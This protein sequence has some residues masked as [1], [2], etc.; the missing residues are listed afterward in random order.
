[1]RPGAGR[2]DR[3]GAGRRSD[4][5]LSWPYE[6]VSRKGSPR[7]RPC[8][9][10]LLGLPPPRSP[11]LLVLSLP[12]TPA[13]A[14][15]PMRGR[16]GGRAREIER[17]RERASERARE[18]ERGREGGREREREHKERQRDRE[19][20]RARRSPLSQ[21]VSVVFSGRVEPAARLQ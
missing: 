4:D 6:C 11:P 9:P 3:I 1:M 18:R 8:S 15:L 17:E 7:S 10:S 16:E 20:E 5:G 19:T 14:P 12:T 2:A 21:S 13:V